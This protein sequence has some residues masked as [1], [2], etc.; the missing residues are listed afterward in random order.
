[1]KI[2]GILLIFWMWLGMAGGNITWVYQRHEAGCPQGPWDYIGGVI[3][4]PLHWPL[5]VLADPIYGCKK[6]ENQP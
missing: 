6:K 1:M 2:L 5:H 4:A 3:L